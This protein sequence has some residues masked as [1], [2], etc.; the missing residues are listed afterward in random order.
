LHATIFGEGPERPNVVRAVRDAGVEDV[1]ALPGF[2]ERVELEDALRSATCLVLPSARE[3]YGLVVVE[4][5]ALG[6]PVVL[7]AG[8]DN[9]ATELVESGVN[10]FVARTP[11]PE[12]LADAIVAAHDGGT[13]LRQSTARWFQDNADRLDATR[14]ARAILAAYERRA[15]RPALSPTP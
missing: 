14:S 15:P 5:A 11:R 7:V 12:D 3:G 4:A 8:E 2:V 1:T 6:T 13:D 9:A 10:G